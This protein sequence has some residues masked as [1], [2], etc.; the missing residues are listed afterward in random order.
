MYVYTYIC[1]YIYIYV[2]YIYTHIYIYVYYILLL[3]CGNNFCSD[4]IWETTPGFL[5]FGLLGAHGIVNLTI[6]CKRK[7]KS[8]ISLYRMI[9][10]QKYT[11]IHTSFV[12]IVYIHTYITALHY[13]ASHRIAL[14]YITLHTY[15][16][17]IYI[18]TS[19]GLFVC[20]HPGYIGTIWENIGTIWA[21]I[22]TI[23]KYV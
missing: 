17:H 13:I 19:D 11:E 18:I 16:I 10:V 23:N 2:L 3:Y 12:Y 20:G 6:E 7:K 4:F 21:N 1:T 5:A 14:H 9:I 15:S 22:G 8:E